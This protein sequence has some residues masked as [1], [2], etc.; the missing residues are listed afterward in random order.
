[1]SHLL[2]DYLAAQLNEHL[3]RRRV[4]VWYD[5]R[6]EF[7][8]FVREL[9]G[10]DPV[11]GPREVLLAGI[12]VQ[13]AIHDGSLYS[14]R[15]RVEPLVA[16]DQPAPVL[17]YLPGLGSDP[18]GSV[19]MELELAGL[20]WERPLKAVARI[21]L[22]QRF[23][24][25]VVDELLNRQNVT[26]D[27]LV[28][29]V[30]SDSGTAPSVLK[31]LLRG[32]SAEEQLST[33]FASPGLDAEIAAKEAQEELNKLLRSSLDLTVEGASLD[34]WRSIAVRFV[35][36]VEFRADLSTDPPKE[37]AEVSGTTAEVEQNARAIAERLR[38]D[39]AT[40]YEELADRA[41]QEL[42]LGPASIDALSLGA[43]DTFRFEE[44]AL[45]ERCG[46]LLRDRN[47]E[48]VIAIADARAS[49]FW[50]VRSLERRA[51]WEAVQLAAELGAAADEVAGA[52]MKPP[53]AVGDWIHRYAT[54]WH[55]LDLTQRRFEAWLP[56]LD[57]DPDEQA[58]AAVRHRYD[59]VLARLAQGFVAALEAAGWSFDGHLRQTSIFDDVVAPMP[60]KVA[61]FLVD[62]MRYE[63]G[64]EL[65]ERLE[66]YAEVSLRPAVG[67]LPSITKTGMAAL[68]P[69]AAIS[70]DVVE[71]GGKLMARVDGADLGD[72]AAR[73]S[74]IKALIPASVD[75]ELGDVHSLTKNK[76]QKRIGDSTL[77]VV[78]SQ[79]IDFFGEGGFQARAVMDNVIES[80]AR[81]VRKLASLGVERAVIASDHGH[82]YGA[83]DRE[84]AMRIDAPGGAQV[85]L[86]RRCWV[87]RG[88]AT[89]PA[90]VRVA[91]RTLGNDTDLDF[92]FPRGAGVFKAGGDLAFHHG[93]PS[94]QELVIPVITVRSA[95]RTGETSAVGASLSV[96]DI[97]A[98]VTN[99]IFSVRVLVTSLL[100]GDVPIKPLL[101]SDQK[102]VGHVGLVVGGEYDRV[103]GTIVIGPT[104]EVTM[105]FVLDDDQARSVRV[106]VIDPATDATLYRSPTDIPVQLGVV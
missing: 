91:A 75:L 7:A 85:E 4:V 13:L 15:N 63:M 28:S 106:V 93:G 9:A 102:P 86:H 73:T 66:P 36:A 1:M 20:R 39:H 64:V 55:R 81:A 45:L 62:A 103:T 95:V 46:E 29:A 17:L 35:L 57:D 12:P 8:S 10:E 101:L 38:R 50:L 58:V 14:L 53:K 48:R 22:R 84:E 98:V 99:R 76:L 31:T 82:L 47:Y 5:P 16:G 43:V 2:H 100:G 23:T 18:H 87:G 72:R 67:V 37:L 6:R 97:P 32:R 19:L 59:E 104:A 77:V 42:N 70:Y 24:D 74:R 78:R 30:V 80:L 11:P 56:N 44:A 92:V 96:T 33:W 65:A 25:G 3:S 90:C 89:P 105:G 52:L 40:V 69:G 68:M 94:L 27:D 79:E 41:A 34:K 61:Y 21:A 54:S 83:G 88:G 60:G 71:S 49:S 26:Y 51:Q